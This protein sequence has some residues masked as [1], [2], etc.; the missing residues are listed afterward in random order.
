LAPAAAR[1][2]AAPPA[3]ATE[4]ARRLKDLER[5]QRERAV[6]DL[7]RTTVAAVLGHDDA[8]RVEDDLA[9]KTAGFDSLT[10]GELRKRLCARTGLALPVTLAFDHPTP[11]ALAA[12]LLR[13][14]E[15]AAPQPPQLTELDRLEAALADPADDEDLRR[16]VAERMAGLLARWSTPAP[17][18]APH[19]SADSGDGADR[20]EAAS[21]A[22]LFELIDQEFGGLPR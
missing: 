16:A 10:G 13:K 5:P 17:A 11:N 1:R 7:I 20:I 2:A 12:Y 22:D 6:L 21:A 8:S 9:F 18:G 4:L 15:P 14:L 3:D 19:D